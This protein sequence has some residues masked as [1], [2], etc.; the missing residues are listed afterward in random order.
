MHNTEQ[1]LTPLSRSPRFRTILLMVVSAI[2]AT[3]AVRIEILNNA[4]GGMLP[5]RER[6]ERGALV[7]WRQAP[8]TSEAK[9][10]EL[11]RPQDADKQPTS[12]LTADEQSQMS[13]EVHQARA[14]DA[15]RDVVSS[16]GLLQYMLVP[17]SL[18]TAFSLLFTRR[19]SRSTRLLSGAGLSVA[20]VAGGLML[21]RQYYTSLGW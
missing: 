11:R 18:V 15:L 3:T 7:K 12:P 4:A 13:R 10:R 1:K 16:W 5:S 9:W 8:W 14:S 21:Y 19:A 2:I 6:D 20:L 17:I